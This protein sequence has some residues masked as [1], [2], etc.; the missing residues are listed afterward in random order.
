MKEFFQQRENVVAWMLILLFVLISI[1]SM[2]NLSLTADEGKHYKYGV[3]VLNRDSTRLVNKKGLVDDSKMPFSALNALPAKIASFFPNDDINFL[4]YRRIKK[5]LEVFSTARLMTIL[6]SAFVAWLVFYW[7]RILYGFIPAI[8][9]LLLYIFD[10]NI[11]AHSQLVTTDLYGIGMTLFCFYYAWK[12]SKDKNSQTGFIL[13]IMLGIS[14]L[15]KYSSLYLYPLVLFTLVVHDVFFSHFLS[16]FKKVGIYLGKILYWVGFVSIVSLIIINLGYWFNRSFTPLKDYNF[17]SDELKIIQ[18]ANTG[19]E[20]IPIPVPYPYLEGIDLV[21]FRERM[22]VG[23]GRIYLLGN[24]RDGDGFNGYY[25]VAS[26]LKVPIAIQILLLLALVIYVKD[27]K[28]QERI[29]SDEI[30]L[31]FPVLFFIIYFNL[32]YNTQLGIRH[33]LI[34][35]PLMYVFSGHLFKNWKGFS[36]ARQTTL[37]VLGVYLIISV[38]SY[39]PHYLAYFNEVVWD[40]KMA[41][42]YLA[43][44]NL[45]WDQGKNYLAEYR[46]KHSDVLYAPDII[47]AGQIIVPVND[48][49][50]V[51]GELE[52][53]RWLR[54]NFEPTGTIAYS[55]LIYDIS[56]QEVDALCHSKYICP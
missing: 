24:L 42:K 40:R 9:S 52:D 3:N 37:F 11:I 53:F 45:D 47:S 17:H 27:K 50:G 16:S 1:L 55:Y 36:K 14:Q 7:S 31:L 28:R 5:F 10:P 48:L 29:W 20:N 23:Y 4:P 56:Q 30:F 33:Y 26:L 41:Y 13:A 12:F 19:L 44:S 18:E 2:K 25:F 51:F 15:A 21:R 46:E 6:F 22:G 35:F 38:L 34:I 39:F 49:V 32:F 54:E 8:A 43:D